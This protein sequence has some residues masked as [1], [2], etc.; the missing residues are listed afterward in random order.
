MTAP[1]R[2]RV[3]AGEATTRL[4]ETSDALDAVLTSRGVSE[5]GR[6]AARLVTEEVVLNAIEH[7]GARYV[8][9][10]AGPESETCRLVFVDDGAP[11]DPTTHRPLSGSGAPGKARPRGRG[12]I[13]VH[14]FT[15]AIEHRFGGGHNRL[16]VLLV[17]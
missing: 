14:A 11:F 17:E 6:L 1:L 13:L 4:R 8:S 12:L 9:V 3:E 5:R 2:W 15:R 10:E 7:G 16:S